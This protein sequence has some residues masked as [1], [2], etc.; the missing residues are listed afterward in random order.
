MWLAFV[1]PSQSFLQPGIQGIQLL[2]QQ[3]HTHLPLIVSEI[4]KEK[5]I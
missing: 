4:Y 3:I 2:D 1:N 5:H